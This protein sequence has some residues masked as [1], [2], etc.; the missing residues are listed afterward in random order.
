MNYAIQGSC[1]M[2]NH[3]I[4]FQHQNSEELFSTVFVCSEHQNSTEK[5]ANG[6]TVHFTHQYLASKVILET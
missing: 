3:Y 1:M 2:G 6:H 4:D 5:I